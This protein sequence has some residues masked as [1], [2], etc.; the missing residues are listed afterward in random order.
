MWVNR[1][2]FQ[3]VWGSLPVLFNNRLLVQEKA[4]AISDRGCA[5]YS[6][7]APCYQLVRQVAARRFVEISL[8][9]NFTVAYISDSTKT[10]KWWV[11][12]RWNPEFFIK[13]FSPEMFID[14]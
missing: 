9:L 5:R 12:F 2:L 8:T 14:N 11:Y 13:H 6:R 7:G 4:P 3:K 10:G 1:C